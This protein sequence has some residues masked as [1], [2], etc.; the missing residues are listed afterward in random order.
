M[1]M[2]KKEVRKHPHPRSPEVIKSLAIYRG[3][4]VGQ[5][6]SEAFDLLRTQ[7]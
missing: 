5:K 3:A 6:Y 1:K 7:N 2:Y 4:Q